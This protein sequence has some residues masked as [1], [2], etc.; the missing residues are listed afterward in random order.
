[1]ADATITTE[2]Y[3]WAHIPGIEVVVLTATDGE[4]YRSTKFQTILG[5][6]V[7]LN[8]NTDADINVTFSGQV[9]TLNLNGVTDDLVTLLLFGIK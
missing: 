7:T 1:M 5:A 3:N 2:A 4:Q 8:A 6:S 9:A